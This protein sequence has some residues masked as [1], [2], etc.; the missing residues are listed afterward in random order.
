MLF[1]LNSVLKFNFSFFDAWILVSNEESDENNVWFGF[2]T[3]NTCVFHL[4]FH[5]VSNLMHVTN[6]AIFIGYQTYELLMSLRNSNSNFV[7]NKK[8]TTAHTGTREKR[9][10]HACL[11]CFRRELF[12]IEIIRDNKAN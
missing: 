6:L 10:A 1:F 7:R 4:G 11:P 9:S 8:E 5:W 3:Q 12:A 2:D